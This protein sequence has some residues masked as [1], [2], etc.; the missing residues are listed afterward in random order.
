MIASTR[1]SF[2]SLRTH[3]LLTIHLL[4]LHPIFLILFVLLHSHSSPVLQIITPLTLEK[5]SQ[6]VV[7][8]TLPFLLPLHE[9]A[10]VRLLGLQV[11]LDPEPVFQVVLEVA[12]VD[13]LVDFDVPDFCQSVQSIQLEGACVQPRH[14][15]DMLCSFSV[16][17]PVPPFSIL[18]VSI[19]EE[20]D[21]VAVVVIALE[22]AFIIAI[23]VFLERRQ[24]FLAV[25][26]IVK[27]I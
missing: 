23:F 16:E 8:S 15:L 18:D 20:H 1:S 22:L 7:L 21:A 24:F 6:V 10:L 3:L 13:A 5:V 11:E 14:I 27:P 12:S 9:V 4:A 25:S 26:K 2:Y 17:H 19:L